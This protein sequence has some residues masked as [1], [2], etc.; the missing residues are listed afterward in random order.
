[1]S[2]N[3]WIV[4]IVG[5]LFATGCVSQLV[6]TNPPKPRY[7][8]EPVDASALAGAPVAWSLIVE[9]PGASRAYDTTKIAVSRSPGRIEYFA[10]GEWASRAPVVLQTALIR[11]FEDSGRIL[12]VGNRADIALSDLA[13]QTDLRRID[14]DVANGQRTARLDVYVRLTNG[15]SVVFA[16]APFSAAAPAASGSGDDVA[17]AFDAAFRDVVVDVANWAFEEG[18]KAR[19]APSGA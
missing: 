17:A 8:V 2:L 12:T 19:A 1:M 11:T 15:R 9:T 13:L 10:D 4:M 16:A 18:E 6:A 5:A 3:R 7:M 14:L